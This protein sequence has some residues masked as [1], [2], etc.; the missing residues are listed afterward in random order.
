V[1]VVVRLWTSLRRSCH[2]RMDSS[3]ASWTVWMD[4]LAAGNMSTRTQILALDHPQSTID[5]RMNT[6]KTSF[7]TDF[8]R[9]MCGICTVTLATYVRKTALEKALLPTAG[10]TEPDATSTL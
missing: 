9:M 2:Q 5:Y 3:A 6:L 7:K 10:A 1:D 4:G 8:L